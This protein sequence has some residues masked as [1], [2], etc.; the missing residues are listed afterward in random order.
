ME[1]RKCL[2][3]K[4]NKMNFYCSVLRVLLIANFR[5]ICRKSYTM[6]TLPETGTVT[7]Q[8]MRILKN[9]FHSVTCLDLTRPTKMTAPTKQWVVLIGIPRFEATR[10]VHTL[11]NSMINP[12]KI[13]YIITKHYVCGTVSVLIGWRQ[14]RNSHFD[15]NFNKRSN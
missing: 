13:K 1:C 6:H 2:I 8:A 7:S 3:K 14:A 15:S 4:F 11:P 9:T 10:T 5:L 12:L